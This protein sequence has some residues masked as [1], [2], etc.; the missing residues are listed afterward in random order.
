MNT[1]SKNALKNIVKECLI[2]ILAEGLIGN[3]KATLRETRELRGALQESHER[4]SSRKISEQTLNQPTQISKTRQTSQRRPSYLDSIKMG[5]DAASGKESNAIQ[6]KVRSITNDPIMSDILADTAM[7]TLREQK[8]GSRPQGP[9]IM[10]GGDEA[11]RI[12]D[13]SSPEELFSENAGKWANLAFAP[14]IRN[15]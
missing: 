1:K 6:N 15:R 10:S 7:T 8:E 3:S 9:S 14:S 12:V 2:E 4:S 13:Q 11:A 5:V